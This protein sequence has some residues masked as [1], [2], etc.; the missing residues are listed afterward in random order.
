M[1]RVEKINNSI[2]F[3]SLENCWNSLL[4]K[5]GSDNIFLT[6]EWLFTWWEVF[7]E[8]KEL[9]LLLIKK[10]GE[11]IIGIAPLMI[12]KGFRFL[13]RRLRKVEFIG[14][15]KC[16]YHDFIIIEKRGE[17]LKSI[18]DFFSKEYRLW[19]VIGLRHIPETSPNLQLLRSK[20]I[21]NGLLG[22][23][24]IIDQC[25]YIFLYGDWDKFVKNLSRHL[26]QDLRRQKRRLEKRGAISVTQVQENGDPRENLQLLNKMFQQRIGDKKE[27]SDFFKGK[28]LSFLTKIYQVMLS[29]H[30]LSI[31]ALFL[32]D[33]MIAYV[34]GF[35]YR[36]TFYYWN[37]SFNP[38]YHSFSPGK[39]LTGDIIKDCIEDDIRVFDFLSGNEEYKLKWTDLAKANYELCYFKDNILGSIL[40]FYY[41]NLRP[42]FKSSSLAKYL[43]RTKF[44]DKFYRKN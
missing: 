18:F 28:N 26:R 29:R 5:S 38:A 33:K 17:A 4:E 40:V 15:G 30:W 9:C 24:Y 36:G 3:L 14:S 10:E 44:T 20:E 12:S 43:I 2:S 23:E 19:D 31:S 11:E 37:V 21:N 7:G 22:V 27:D 41:G 8:D 39:I 32:D 34:F 25:P 6:F 42:K 35:K 13:G 16:D 1:L